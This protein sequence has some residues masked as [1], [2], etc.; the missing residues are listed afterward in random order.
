M[1]TE[2][3]T[4]TKSDLKAVI[5]LGASTPELDTG[6]DSPSFYGEISLATW[7]E[8]DRSVALA[9]KEG[10]TL[11]GFLLGQVMLG[12]DG[13]INTTVVD[14]P[15][16]GM[17][18]AAQLTEAAEQMFEER[19]CNRVWSIVEEG[20]MAMLGLKKKLGYDWGA[21][22]FKLVDRMIG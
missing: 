11:V 17:G 19:G 5:N 4:L 16:R 13:Y 1:S 2:I 21:Q 7:L 18:I 15:Y 20:N 8:D 10:D 12:R 6:N 22:N 3:V 9:A 14:E